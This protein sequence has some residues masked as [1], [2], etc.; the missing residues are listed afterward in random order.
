MLVILD[1]FVK[2]EL[3]WI[4]AETKEKQKPYLYGVYSAGS[5]QIFR[6]PAS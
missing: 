6:Q 5:M 3:Q 4:I 1:G 2:S